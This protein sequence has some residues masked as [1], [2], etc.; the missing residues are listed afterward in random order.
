MYEEYTDAKGR[1]KRRRVS[2]TILPHLT[3]HEV[4][5][6]T[7]SG[8]QR[9]L[10]PGLS[11]R[12]ANILKSVQKRAHYLD[13]GF[14]ICGLRFGWTFIIGM[15]TTTRPCSFLPMKHCKGIT[16]RVRVQ[17]VFLSQSGDS[18]FS[19][20]TQPYPLVGII[21]GA[22]DA[23]DAALN[24]YLVV[25]K[26][27]QA[28]I[29]SWLL[30]RMLLNNAMSAGVG[31]IPL[32][33]DIILAVYKANSRNAAL[34]EEFLRIRGEEFLKLEHERTEDAQE[35]RPGAGREK[36]EKDPVKGEKSGGGWFRRR[37]KGKGKAVNSEPGSDTNL[38][39]DSRFVENM[40]A[41]VTDMSLGQ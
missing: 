20:L 35:I 9:Q 32:V 31:L 5:T 7:G 14:R 25:R 8:S 29:P 27:R 1:Q 16:R 38:R 17:A 21:P 33:G 41:E 34:L 2:E 19:L 4:E 11:K 12:D 23:A 15:Y 6:H 39:R 37:S 40:D 18:R 30:R 3:L 22:G 24:Y 28:E 13:K 36:D 10:P 26:A